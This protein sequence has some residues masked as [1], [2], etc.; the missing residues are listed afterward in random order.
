[1][2]PTPLELAVNELSERQIIALRQGIARGGNDAKRPN[3]W[4]EYGFPS[5]LVFE[6]L[7]R[8]YE[9]HGVAHGVVHR[10]LDKCWETMPEV[11]QG[12]KAD[13]STT[14]TPWEKSIA[15]QF[16]KLK[17]WKHF[18][19]A[20]RMRM[21]GHYSGIL[22]QV[23]DGKLWSDP[24]AQ[25]VGVLVKLIPAWEGQLEPASWDT[26]PT[27]PTYG[28]PTM[29]SFNE[30]AVKENDNREPGRAMQVHPS[31]V[32]IVGDYRTGVPLLK[33]G[34][35]DFVTI[36]KVVGGAG[37]SFLKNASRQLNINFDKDTQMADV[38][39][40]YGVPISELHT[41]FDEVAKGMNRG[42]DSVLAT[43]G[44]SV[45]TL[46]ST[47]PDPE[48]PFNVALQSAC[49]SVQIPVKI[50]V[51]MQTGERASTEDIKDFNKRGQGRRVNE[52]SDDIEGFVA[53]LSKYKLLD[54]P[55][56]GTDPE[57]TCVW[58]DLGEATLSERLANAKLMAET[59]NLGNATGDKYFSPEQIV[60]TAG[61]EVE[62]MPEP[63]PDVQPTDEELLAQQ[64]PSE[65]VA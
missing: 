41:A 8:M 6:D 23:A 3:A 44:A 39:K 31:R 4:C 21:V 17:V 58:D 7:Y 5:E 30:A 59:N 36:E 50:V 42:M 10:L 57:V 19:E 32:F 20:D 60:T 55:L 24:L 43:Q 37:E 9:R 62:D 25:K 29:W 61:F 15:K 26:D 14:Q 56:S 45:S 40:I 52:L 48:K 16:K 34:Y 12:D 63:L 65:Q 47:V 2:Q 53:H 1:M 46:V 18:K 51:G 22:L 33:A 54:T 11:I 64:P 27:S 28:E 13:E 38:A 49:A 35:N